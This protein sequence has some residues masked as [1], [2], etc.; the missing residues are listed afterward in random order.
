MV[1][2]YKVGLG[3]MMVKLLDDGAKGPGFEPGSCLLDSDSPASK[4][5]YQL[6]ISPTGDRSIPKICMSGE[7]LSHPMVSHPRVRQHF[8]TVI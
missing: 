7:M 6:N 8:C 5:R 2:I 4:S 1:I 3:V